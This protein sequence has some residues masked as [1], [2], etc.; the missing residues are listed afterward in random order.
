MEC[1]VWVRQFGEGPQS[2]CFASGAQ[3]GEQDTLAVETADDVVTS[4]SHFFQ[5]FAVFRVDA[6]E[7]RAVVF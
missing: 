4:T 6:D 1:V 5:L 2:Y 3:T 7:D